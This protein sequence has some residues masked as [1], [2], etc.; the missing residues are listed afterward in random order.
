M[1]DRL[2]EVFPTFPPFSSERN[3][4]RRCADHV[5][6]ARRHNRYADL[7]LSGSPGLLRQIAPAAVRCTEVF[8]DPPDAA[9]FPE[10]EAYVARAVEKRRREFTTGRWCAR[11]A[12]QQLGIAPAPLLR[13]ERGA[14][15]WPAGVRGSITH[16]PGYRAAAV[17]W[18][19]QVSALGIDAEPHEPL[20]EGVLDVVALP[21]E[22]RGLAALGTALHWPRVLFSCKEAVYKAW[23]PLTREWLDFSEA[24]IELDPAGSFTAR[25]HKANARATGFTG[26]WLVSSGLVVTAVWQAR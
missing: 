11:A 5:R 19:S 7:V 18:A 9:L 10:E 6:P 25:V 26:R 20:P 22:Q 16:C 1:T 24:S 4:G 14:V 2:P 13:D 23:Y 17:A 21:D 15:R 8:A 12:L 3:S